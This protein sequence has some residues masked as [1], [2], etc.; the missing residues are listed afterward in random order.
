[1]I[2]INHSVFLQAIS[3]IS[4]HNKDFINNITSFEQI[5]TLIKELELQK[6][7]CEKN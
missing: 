6:E 2:D 4:I 3:K 7:I 1:M 5:P